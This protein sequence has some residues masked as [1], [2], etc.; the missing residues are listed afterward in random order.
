MSEDNMSNMNR[1][2]ERGRKAAPDIFGSLGKGMIDRDN[3]EEL[4]ISSGLTPLGFGG[5]VRDRVLN[6]SANEDSSVTGSLQNSAGLT[7]IRPIDENQNGNLKNNSS[8]L[9][10]LCLGRKTDKK[11]VIE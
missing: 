11:Q 10:T 8:E 5:N 7:P 6:N 1:K 4:S 3:L 9:S 2:T